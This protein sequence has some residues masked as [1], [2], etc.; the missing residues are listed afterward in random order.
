[1]EGRSA[2]PGYY[3]AILEFESGIPASLTYNGYGYFMMSDLITWPYA[4]G[5]NTADDRIR[6]R[7]EVR[8]GQQDMEAA[9]E[10]WRMG[11]ERESTEPPEAARARPEHPKFIGDLGLLIV[12][13]ER[14][15]I[16]Q[17]PNGLYIHGDDGV[18]EVAVLDD[19][20]NRAIELEEL[21]DAV[22]FGRP[23]YHDGQWGLSTLEVC[24][25]MLESA[26]EHREVQMT[27][28]TRAGVQ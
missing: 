19:S 23:V 26:R 8:S 20:D 13:C 24:L 16:R 15:D 18:R 10:S 27:H 17:S 6:A 12:S 22:M 25:G 7:K 4:G 2:A 1:M 5:R 28:Q 14:G 3:T 9:K 11:G 21:Y